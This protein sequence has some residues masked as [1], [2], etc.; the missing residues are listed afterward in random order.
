MEL[1]TV[2]EAARELRV[3][4]ITIRRYIKSG[5][6]KCVRLGR[7]IRLRRD[8]LDSLGPPENIEEFWRHVE[9]TS[10]TDPFWRIVGM[11]DF[12]PAGGADDIHGTVAHAYFERLKRARGE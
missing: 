3:S 5:R 2:R 8:D 9:P 7:T 4:P 6:L 11:A 10:E 12:E 1:L